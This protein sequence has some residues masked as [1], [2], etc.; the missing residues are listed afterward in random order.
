MKAAWMRAVA[1]RA[2]PWRVIGLAFLL[3]GGY[4]TVLRFTRGLGGATNLSDT[5]PWGLWVGF[6]ILC[7][8]GLAAG[9]FTVSALVYVLRLDRY[10]A[11]ARPAV[12]TAF[13]GYLLVV[14]GLM[15]DL[16][17]PW[18]I[19]HP[20][21]M[22]NPHSVMFEIAWCVTLYTTVLAAEVSAMVFEK[23]RMRR[24]TRVVHALTLPLTVAAVLLSMLHQSSLGSLFLIVPGRLHEL[25]YTPLL[26]LLFFISAVGVGLAMTI[27]EST[28]SSRTFRRPVELE[29]LAPVGRLASVVLGF[30]LI[31]RWADMLR[32]GSLAALWPLDRAAGFFLLETALVAVPVV[33]FASERVARNGRWLYHTAQTVVLGFI[34]GRL[35]VAV[36]G[37]EVVSGKT[38]VPYW[39]EI[40]VTG[41]LVTVGVAGFYLAARYLPV[42]ERDEDLED[43]ERTWRIETQRRAAFALARKASVSPAGPRGG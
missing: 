11:L 42:F 12:L 33:L 41:M 35:N 34:V 38:Y 14:G 27:M 2:T 3:A 4:A 10:R 22:W 28:L 37:F 19:W 15:F 7:G 25:W 6:D 8:V 17:H 43:R 24:C 23:L 18:R 32:S 26:P 29:L 9:G 40:A 20:M 16:G 1:R 31:L 21:V 13:I 39:T 5:F 30:Y 36:T